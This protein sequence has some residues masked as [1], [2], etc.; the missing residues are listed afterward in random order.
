MKQNAMNP[1]LKP[2]KPT[3]T[4]KRKSGATTKRLSGKSEKL[5]SKAPLDDQG[6]PLIRACPWC[7]KI[8]TLRGDGCLQ[9]MACGATT[10]PTEAPFVKVVAPHR[11]Q[12]IR[13]VN[14]EKRRR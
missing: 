1:S 6:K 10:Y 8:M 2:I 12:G 4:N 5:I 13:T 3:S 14:M 11:G 7:S 9:C